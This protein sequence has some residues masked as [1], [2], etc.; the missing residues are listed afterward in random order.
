MSFFFKSLFFTY[1]YI[2][3]G[4]EF[5]WVVPKSPEPPLDPPMNIARLQWRSHRP[6]AWAASRTR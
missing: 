1:V 4:L 5:F 3:I 2:Y 6:A